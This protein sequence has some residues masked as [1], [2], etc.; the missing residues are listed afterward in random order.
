VRPPSEKEL[1]IGGKTA[2]PKGPA[3]EVARQDFNASYG[4]VME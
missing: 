1:F 3:G 4:Y 2:M